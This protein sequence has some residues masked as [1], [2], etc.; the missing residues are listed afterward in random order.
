MRRTTFYN[1]ARNAILEYGWYIQFVGM[2]VCAEPGCDGGRDDPVTEPPFAY[3]V[4][5]TRYDDH[6]EVIIFGSCMDCSGRAL[7]QVGEAVRDHRDVTDPEV[8][9]D[10][11]G[12]GLVRMIEVADS[13]THLLVAN[14]MYRAAGCPPI[15]ALQLVTAT[16]DGRFPWDADYPLDRSGQPLLGRAG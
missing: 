15:P 3:T 16:E 6:P 7:N 2:G 11:F 1:R 5:L 9:D 8:L 4:G 14:G 13:S 12:P 10:L